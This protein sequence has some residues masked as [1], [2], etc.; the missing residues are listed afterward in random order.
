MRKSR[1]FFGRWQNLLGLTIVALFFVVAMGA[2][3]LA[4]PPD[5]ENFSPFKI[6]PSLKGVM[7]FPPNEEA[8]LGTIAL[9]VMRRQLDIYYTLVWGTRS[10][11]RF[12]VVVVFFTA[13]I[14]ILTGAVSAFWGG[15]ADSLIMRVTDAFLAFPIIAAVVFFSQLLVLSQEI[16]SAK[17]FNPNRTGSLVSPIQLLFAVV[18]PVILALVLFSWMPYARLTHT[19]VLKIKEMEFVQASKALGAG[20]GK[21]LLKHLIPNSISPAIVLAASQVGGIVLLQA[22]MTFIGIDAGSEWGALLSMGRRWIIGP[23]N[24]PLAY[25]WV[26]IPITVTLILFGVGWNLLGDGLNDWLNPRTN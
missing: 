6:V 5:P 14:G 25:W 19:Q 13:L 22:A 23:I 26:F 4:P 15:R 7:P 18:D 12:G 3:Y 8:P 24:E 11:L 2:P 9:G 1:A 10:A 17:A 21:V 16:A 20:T